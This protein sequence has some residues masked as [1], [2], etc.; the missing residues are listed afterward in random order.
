MALKQVI[1]E[2]MEEMY[3]ITK[4]QFEDDPTYLPVAADIED[5][6]LAW[7]ERYEEAEQEYLQK[8][9]LTYR[10]YY[11]AEERFLYRQGMRDC[12]ALLKALR[13]LQ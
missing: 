8:C 3:E 12:I 9:F 7:K 10:F 1:D 2:M 4:D 5:M 6:E 11:Y 13:V